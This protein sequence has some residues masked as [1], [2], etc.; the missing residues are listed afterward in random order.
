V[1]LLL[2]T[3]RYGECA[4]PKLNPYASSDVR[5]RIWVT[6]ARRHGLYVSISSPN[7]AL[8]VRATRELLGHR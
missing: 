5:E 2:T 4:A 8:T 1:P 6:L 7:R 3:S